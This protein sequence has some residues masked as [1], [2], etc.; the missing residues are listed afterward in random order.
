M[1]RSNIVDHQRKELQGVCILLKFMQPRQVI[2]VSKINSDFLANGEEIGILIV[3]IEIFCPC[4]IYE[5]QQLPTGFVFVDNLDRVLDKFLDTAQSQSEGI[6]RTLQAL[7]QVDAHQTPDTF[8]TTL[9]RQTRAL[10]VGHVDVLRQTR[11]HN[12]V[13]RRVNGQRQRNQ[14][15]IDL[16]VV[17]RITEVRQAGPERDGFQALREFTD[18]SRIVV[19]LNVSPG[20]CDGYAIQHLKEVK[21]QVLE[22]FIC[23]SFFSRQFAPCIKCFLGSAEDLVNRGGCIKLFIDLRRVAL[24]SQCKLVFQVVETVVYRCRREHQHLC[25][26]TSSNDLIQ[27]L[28][29]SILLGVFT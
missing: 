4:Q 18:I 28:E 10:V 3:I 2:H 26:D 20:S 12:I 29:I 23:S 14:H 15:L 8:L 24:I 22:Q 6:D 13:G 17:D 1:F 27:Q 11:G 7:K 19:L 9:L 21:V 5:I 25:S 16:I